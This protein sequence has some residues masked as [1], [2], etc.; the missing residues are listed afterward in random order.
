MF[1]RKIMKKILVLLLTV[2][3]LGFFGGCQSQPTVDDSKYHVNYTIDDVTYETIDG[4]WNK[5]NVH[6]MIDKYY[7]AQENA[8]IVV[9]VTFTADED[10]HY[11]KLTCKGGIGEVHNAGAFNYLVY[12]ET[13]GDMD[14]G[15]VLLKAGTYQIVL[16]AND[17][18]FYKNKGSFLPPFEREYVGINVYLDVIR[19]N[20]KSSTASNNAT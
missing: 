20:D 6:E 18:C 15:E 16:T 11:A 3:V 4:I 9:T 12:E 5:D 2:V 19:F 8:D 13:L 17:F 7:D 14:N 1:L 10:F